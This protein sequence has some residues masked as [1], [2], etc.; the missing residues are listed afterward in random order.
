[1]KEA[2]D[3]VPNPFGSNPAPTLA[4][5]A[6]HQEALPKPQAAENIS[7]SGHRFAPARQGASPAASWVRLPLITEAPA[8]VPVSGESLSPPPSRGSAATPT[9]HVNKPPLPHMSVP[10]FPGRE[11]LDCRGGASALPPT[12]EPCPVSTTK[13]EEKISFLQIRALKTLRSFPSCV[14]LDKFPDL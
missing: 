6:R 5:Y 11:A 14:T 12:S 4:S 9:R 7:G 10:S 13:S 8:G 1:M 2:Q 3:C